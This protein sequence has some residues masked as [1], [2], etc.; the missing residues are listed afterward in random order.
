[1]S[2]R[3]RDKKR[4]DPSQPP[5]SEIAERQRIAVAAQL[6]R[7]FSGPLPPPEVLV[8]YNDAVPNGAERI[9]AMAEKQ[10]DHRMQLERQVVNSDIQRSNLGLVAGLIIALAFLGV[11]YL[12]IDHGHE[13]AGAVLGTIDIV[14]LVGVFVYGTI[15]RRQ[16]RADRF[17][18]IA[19]Q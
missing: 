12:L 9:I 4:Q 14:G 15:S 13:T 1:V 7:S 10:S 6:Q 3:R 16:E 17:R 2:K 5:S 8:H 19:G 11:S 18:E